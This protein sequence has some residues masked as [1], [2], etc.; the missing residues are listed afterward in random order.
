[1]LNIGIPGFP[2]FWKP[3]YAN[4]AMQHRDSNDEHCLKSQMY[5]GFRVCIS[6]LYLIQKVWLDLWRL[7]FKRAW[8]KHSISNLDFFKCIFKHRISF[9]DMENPKAGSQLCGS[10]FIK[11]KRTY[12]PI[13]VCRFVLPVS[14]AATR[15]D[16]GWSSC[17]L[18]IVLRGKGT[19]SEC[20]NHESSY[21]SFPLESAALPKSRC[22]F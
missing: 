8:K 6:L 13:I 16:A 18:G 12:F 5:P 21:L 3:T 9:T 22:P 1:M 4:I 2:G 14:R 17:T 15:C 7:Q 11:R 19:D 10:V 20:S